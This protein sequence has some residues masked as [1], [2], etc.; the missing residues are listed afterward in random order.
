MPVTDR[1]TVVIQF[2]SLTF[3]PSRELQAQETLQNG[4]LGCGEGISDLQPGILASQAMIE[5]ILS[6]DPRWQGNVI[7]SPFSLL[8]FEPIYW[9]WVFIWEKFKSLFKQNTEL[10]YIRN[11]DICEQIVLSITLGRLL[12]MFNF[13]FTSVANLCQLNNCS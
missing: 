11:K 1:V 7:P 5:K 13:Q 4:Q 9:S 2:I 8:I 10:V 12:K 6:E 3:P